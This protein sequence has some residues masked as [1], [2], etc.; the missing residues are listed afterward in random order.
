MAIQLL[1]MAAPRARI[2]AQSALA[3]PVTLREA[4]A[5]AALQSNADESDLRV[6][7]WNLLFGAEDIINS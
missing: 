2:L 4:G 6:E 3:P 7:L 1:R 5:D